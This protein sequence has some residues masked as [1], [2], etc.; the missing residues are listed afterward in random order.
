M[1]MGPYL[2]N[3][4]SPILFFFFFFFFFFFSVFDELGLLA[5]FLSSSKSSH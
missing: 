1:A 3:K 2:L 4:N 5:S